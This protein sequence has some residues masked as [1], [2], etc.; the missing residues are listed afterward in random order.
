MGSGVANA[1]K[2]TRATGFK[3]INQLVQIPRVFAREAPPPP[4][5]TA[6]SPRSSR[7]RP[8][9]ISSTSTT[10]SRNK[11]GLTPPPHNI[12]F[13]IMSWNI[14]TI[15]GLEAVKC[16]VELSDA[17]ITIKACILSVIEEV[18]NTASD[19]PT[20]YGGPKSDLVKVETFG[21]LGGAYG[22]IGKLEVSFFLSSELRQQ[23]A[24]AAAAPSQRDIDI[25]NG[26]DVS[27]SSLQ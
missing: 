26:N 19:D 15:G 8:V 14:I 13:G 25:A 21:H 9:V 7:R 1:G 3:A 5:M 18:I 4:S 10:V 23:L 17:P 22:S 6:S 2:A 27:V 24:N 16:E 11:A 12:L 20:L